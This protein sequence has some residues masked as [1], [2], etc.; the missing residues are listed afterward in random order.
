VVVLAALLLAL[1]LKVYVAEAYQIRGSSM[2]TTFEDGER[3]MVQKIFYT[4]E[5]GDIVIFS[6]KEDPRKDLIKRVIGL[7]GDVI[8]IEDG[9]VFINGEK[10]Q[11]DY[12][13]VESYRHESYGPRKVAPNTYFVLG[14]NRDQ[15]LDSRIFDSIDHSAIKGKVI[16]R[17][18]PFQKVH[19]F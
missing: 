16:L 6:S 1:L 9:E 4:I 5:R 18:W 19:T 15:S 14:D 3:V 2:E 10:L 17:W 13:S 8:R 7:P 11:E 12:A